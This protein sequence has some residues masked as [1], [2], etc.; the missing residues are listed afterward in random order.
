M[1]RKTKER[2]DRAAKRVREMDVDKLAKSQKQANIGVATRDQ[3]P[4][5]HEHYTNRFGGSFVPVSIPWGYDRLEIR[6]AIEWWQ[7]Q[8]ELHP[9]TCSGGGGPCSDVKRESVVRGCRVVLLCP[10]CGHIQTKVPDCVILAY[11][12]WKGDPA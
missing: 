11:R 9:L 4:V 8:D 12:A 7:R 1:L 10:D 2:F 6:S 5:D 3:A